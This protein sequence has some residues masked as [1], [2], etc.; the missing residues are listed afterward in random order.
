MCEISNMKVLQNPS[1]LNTTYQRIATMGMFDGVHLGHQ[2]LLETLHKTAQKNEGKSILFSFDQHPRIVLFDD[3]NI[4]LLNSPEEKIKRL[5]STNINYYVPLQFTKEFA[6]MSAFE[7]VRDILVNEYQVDTLIV[8]YDHHFGRNREGNYEQLLEY[9]DMFGFHVEQFPPISIEEQT[10]SSTKIRKAI[11]DGNIPL[12]NAMLGYDYPL[13]GK[14]I[15]GKGVGRTLGFPTANLEVYSYKLN[16]KNGVYVVEVFVDQ[17][18]YLGMLNVGNQPTVFGKQSQIEVNILDF[19]TDIYGKEIGL[20]LKEFIRE[21]Q[22]FESTETLIAQIQ[23]DEE[24][25]R[26]NFG[27]PY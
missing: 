6:K 13:S 21:E 25:T 1:E 4:K 23:K 8:G 14:V 19:D 22:K 11:L 18:V 26:A 2:K 12:A 20:S 9:A 15:K 16:P 3:N 7:F 27:K 10:I 5:E 24:Y 17:Q